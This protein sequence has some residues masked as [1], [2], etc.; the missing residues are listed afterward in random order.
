[1]LWHL[2]NSNLGGGARSLKGGLAVCP[3]LRVAPYKGSLGP[4]YISLIIECGPVWGRR[5]QYPLVNCSCVSA[6]GWGGVKVK[7]FTFSH[8]RA[9]G[10]ATFLFLGQWGGR[11]VTYFLKCGPLPFP[12][13]PAR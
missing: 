1:V 12:E 10:L 9:G 2:C 11:H 7:P 13:L 8:S 3:L 6:G 4:A 5:G